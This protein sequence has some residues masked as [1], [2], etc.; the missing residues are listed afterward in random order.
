MADERDDQGASNELDPIAISAG[1]LG[2]SREVV[3]FFL[4]LLEARANSV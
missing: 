2:S 4:D 3:P 1:L